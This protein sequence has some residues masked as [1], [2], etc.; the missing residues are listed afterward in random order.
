MKFYAFIAFIASLCTT[1]AFSFG[2][3]RVDFNITFSEV[4]TIGEGCDEVFEIKEYAAKYFLVGPTYRTLVNNFQTPSEEGFFHSINFMSN[5]GYNR[6]YVFDKDVI[7]TDGEYHVKAE[8]FV[9]YQVT[10]AEFVVSRKDDACVAKA[11]LSGFN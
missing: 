9:D 2:D 11:T 5:Y 6:D 4:V 1:S 3:N 10:Y 7:G 8:G